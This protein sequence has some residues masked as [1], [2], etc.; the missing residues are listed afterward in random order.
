M[1]P[2]LEPG[3]VVFATVDRPELIAGAVATMWEPEG[4][5]AIL[6]LEIAAAEGLSVDLPLRQITLRIVSALDGVG[7]TAAVSGALA[8]AGI[9]CNV[10]AAHHHDHL[11]VPERDAERALAILQDLAAGGAG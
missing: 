7:L 8:A 4:L 10:V 1:A 6:P 5:S 3:R 9:A 2:T 11:F